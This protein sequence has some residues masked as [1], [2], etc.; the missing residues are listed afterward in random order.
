MMRGIADK[1]E[2]HHNVRILDEA[3]VDCVILSHRYIAGRQLPDKSVSV[4]DTACA[5]VAIGQGAT[6][7]PV[8]DVTR[9]IQNLTAEINALEREQVT[10]A[11]HDERL[12]EL[13]TKRTESEEELGKLNE[14]WTK[15]KDLVE[16]IRTIRTKLEGTVASGELRVESEEKES[17]TAENSE[18]SENQTQE[19]SEETQHSELTR[20][21]TKTWIFKNRTQAFDRRTAF[22]SG[23]K[24]SDAA[25]R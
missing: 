10:G 16:K 23:R 25:G 4:L 2:A 24:S 17:E 14:Q 11:T 1:M 18:S 20:I 9:R 8:E 21:D 15:E 5:K 6:P 13:K 3:I 19:N 22:D 12:A 7:A